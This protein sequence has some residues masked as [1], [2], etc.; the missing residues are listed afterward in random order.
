M[1]KNTNI[2][3]NCGKQGHSFHQCKLPITSYGVIVFRSSD[4]GVQ[5]L[6]IRRK[7]SFGY[8]DFIRGKYSP[9]NIFQIQN[10][11]NEMS[12]SEKEKILTQPFDTLWCE[13]WCN[14]V[15]SQH[16]NEEQIS[17]KKMELIRNG[18]IVNNELIN[19]K[20]LINKSNT[21]WEE[22]EWEFP[23]GR[24]NFKEKDLECA[25]REFE[26]ETGILSNKISIIENV[27]P[28]EEIF[29]G[30]NH[31][32]YKHKYFLAYMN[33]TEEYLNN[34]Q[35]TE[36]SKIEWKKLDKCLEDIR[37]YNLEKKKVII[38]INKVLQEY[39]LYS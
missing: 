29:I 19:L 34:F 14:S 3:N 10:I 18:V 30:T 2:C 28:F 5:Y 37:P 23:K 13:M 33:E 24:R 11:I 35:V 1:N 17:R 21:K 8:I 22:T 7:D 27:L 15:N 9:Y 31:K 12:M 32:C 6:M 16:K 20:M 36:V 4:S 39:R 25:L 38:N 26:E